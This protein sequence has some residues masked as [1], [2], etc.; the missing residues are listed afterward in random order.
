VRVATVLHPTQRDRFSV[1]VPT[2]VSL[3]AQDVAGVQHFA[4]KRRD[5][6]SSLSYELPL[7]VGEI[8]VCLRNRLGHESRGACHEQSPSV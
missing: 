5:P 1:P 2:F 7:P 6:L 3:P 4:R 8:R